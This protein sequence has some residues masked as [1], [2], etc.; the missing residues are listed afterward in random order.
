MPIGFNGDRSLVG[1]FENDAVPSSEQLKIVNIE[2][3]PFMLLLSELTLGRFRG[4]IL[5]LLSIVG[6]L[7]PRLRMPSIA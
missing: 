7:Y 1:L 3:L 5:V 2:C 4:Q 6:L